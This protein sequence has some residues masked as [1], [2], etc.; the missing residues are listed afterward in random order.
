MKCKWC[1][2]ETD[3]LGYWLM[4]KGLKPWR[5]KIDAILEKL[6]A[7]PTSYEVYVYSKYRMAVKAG[8][9]AHPDEE[10]LDG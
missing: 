6:Q 2:K 8:F 3:W 7:E 5:K 10:Y 4:P 9:K 1:I